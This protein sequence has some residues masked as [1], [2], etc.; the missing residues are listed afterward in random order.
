MER[1]PP[2]RGANSV[3]R[4]YEIWKFRASDPLAVEDMAHAPSIRRRNR[5]KPGIPR[6]L[7]VCPG[8]PGLSAGRNVRGAPRAEA[9][10]HATRTSVDRAAIKTVCLIVHR[11]AATIERMIVFGAR[12][13]SGPRNDS[14]AAAA[15]ARAAGLASP[16]FVADVDQIR[17]LCKTDARGDSRPT[18]HAA[19][20]DGGARPNVEKIRP[21]SID[22][23]PSQ[24]G[25]AL[26]KSG[27]ENL[28]EVTRRL[29]PGIVLKGRV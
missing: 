1:C 22:C 6:Y 24:G 10:G 14:D 2:L 29:K 11:I 15:S 8:G 18:C 7:R 19:L 27:D 13:A 23:G 9:R 25:N 28:N 12:R 17:T 5:S 4:S 3:P 20:R 16:Q 26:K 21:Q